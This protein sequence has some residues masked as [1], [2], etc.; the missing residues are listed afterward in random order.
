MKFSKS[1]KRSIDYAVPSLLAFGAVW[2]FIKHTKDRDIKFILLVLILVFVF[3]YALTTQITKVFY[4]AAK[5]VDVDVPI[6]AVKVI[7][8]T[9]GST[10]T[11]G[12]V[13]NVDIG[14]LTRKLREDIYNT[15]W[16]G[17]ND[18]LW[19]ETS[20]LSDSDLASVYNNWNK[21][22]YSEHG[23]SFTEAIKAEVFLSG[24]FGGSNAY[25]FKE[26]VLA[27]LS[28]IGAN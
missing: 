23:E 6:D 15:P 12:A 26:T 3:A 4:E 1:T 14:A 19:W 16:N 18:Q 5:K 24:F 9:D 13:S 27:K 28:K 22:Y 7:K 10:T 20:L 21:N 11:V 8:N 25:V 2:Y 17:H